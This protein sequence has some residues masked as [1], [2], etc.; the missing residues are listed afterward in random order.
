MQKIFTRYLFG[1]IAVAFCAMMLAGWLVQSKNA[2]VHMIDNSRLK[3]MQVSQTLKA[4]DAE[5]ELLTDSLSEDY[6][7]RAHAFAYIIEQNPDVLDSPEELERIKGLLNVDELHVIDENGILF[8][9]T[10]P[11]YFGMDFKSTDQTAEFLQ[12]L[13]DPEYCLVQDIRPN[14]AE[15]KLFQY[16]GVARQDQKGIVQVGLAPVR[17]LEAQ[18]KNELSYLF[19]IVPVDAGSTIFVVDANTGEFLAHSSEEFLGKSVEDVGFSLEDLADYSNGGFHTFEGRRRFYLI[20][21]EGSRYLG[22]GQKEVDLYKERGEQMKILCVCFLLIS[23]I[24][25]V[26]INHLVKI[27]I[28][29][30]I[31]RIMGNLSDITEGD[32]DTVVKV[33]DNPEFRLLSEK[34]NQM[35]SSILEATVK[36]SRVIDMVDM[37]IG[38]FEIGKESGEVRATDRLARILGW[39]RAEQEDNCRDKEHFLAALEQMKLACEREEDDIYLISEEP[40]RWV[41]IQMNSDESGIFGVVNDVTSDILEKKRIKHERDYD[42]LTGLRNIAKFRRKINVLLKCE[43]E[44]GC[45]AMMMMDLDH[46]KLMNDRYGHDWGDTYLQFTA[47][48]LMRFEGENGI[49]ARRSGDEFCIFVHHF[50]SQEAIIEKLKDFY[51]ELESSLLLFPDGERRTISI[52]VGLAWY[53]DGRTD[54]ETLM[55]AADAALYA[56]K[57][58]G[59]NTFRCYGEETGQSRGEYIE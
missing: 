54:Y 4:N 1:V 34:I 43:E 55:R 18:K 38:V 52:S 12:I 32:L 31:H 41:R 10:I 59:R 2:Q 15:Q 46:F 14:G 8:A 30:G 7:T 13:D 29:N 48:H 57:A 53:G 27:K 44:L 51:R 17:Y 36:V 47:K 20:E 11:K 16:A 3:L 5:L 33:E 26:A 56:A 49:T 58:E 39:N 23:C 35:V 45:C 42:S 19:S 9:G 50:A 22:I 40:A 28:V 25:M 24:L 37:P 6:L 21:R